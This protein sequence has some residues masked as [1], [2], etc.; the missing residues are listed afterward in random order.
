MFQQCRGQPIQFTPVCLEQTRRFAGGFLQ[1]TLNLGI[2]RVGC[3]RTIWFSTTKS[4]VFH[5][6][7]DS[8]ISRR[9]RDRSQSLAHA[10]TRDH[11]TCQVGGL[12]HVVLGTGRVCLEDH[13]FSRSTTHRANDARVQVLLAVA[14]PVVLGTLVGHSECHAVRHDG[15]AVDRVRSRQ[16][17]AEDRV[18]TLVIRNPCAF[19]D[20]HHQRARRTEDECFERIQHILVMDR[21]LIATG[22][23]QRG[24][25]KERRQHV[26]M[27]RFGLMQ[28]R[29]DPVGDFERVRRADAQP[30]VGVARLDLA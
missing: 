11:L 7:A 18:A 10:P 8:S 15:D 12:L 14:V 2:D 4:E 6:S 13:F 21:L 20:T 5:A 1:Q 9:Q 23:K 30:R 25:G 22:C 24:F 26:E 29:Q 19:L 27:G 17:Q 3:C 16:E 28:T